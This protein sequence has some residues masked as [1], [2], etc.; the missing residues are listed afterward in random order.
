MAHHHSKCSFLLDDSN[1]TTITAR[2]G[3]LRYKYV[4]HPLCV[5]QAANWITTLGSMPHWHWEPERYVRSLLR[6]S[7]HLV[8]ILEGSHFYRGGERDPKAPPPISFDHT[9][10]GSPSEESRA[11][12]AIVEH[13][14]HAREAN[15]RSI[16][17]AFALSLSAEHSP[18]VCFSTPR[19]RR[20]QIPPM[21]SHSRFNMH[22]R[23]TENFF[24]RFPNSPAGPRTCWTILQKTSL[25]LVGDSWQ[26]DTKNSRHT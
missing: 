2:K 26:G 18:K 4:V 1:L 15:G 16:L 3:T 17:N 23:F 22:L 12:L 21:V 13:V 6:P 8:L 10:L 24:L 11:I 20:H 25:P 19:T 7:E 9:T 5:L 14:D